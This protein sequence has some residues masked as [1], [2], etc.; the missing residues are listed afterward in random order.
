VRRGGGLTGRRAAALA[1][2]SLLLLLVLAQIVLPQIAASRIRSKLDRYGGG[3]ADV[4]VTAWPAVKL[5]WGD[6]DSV[7]VKAGRLALSPAQ[8]AGLL[9]E[10]RGLARLEISVATVKLGS[11]QLDHAVFEKRG[12]QLSA[13]AHASGAA[14]QAAL[15]AGTSVH[16]LRSG[17]G[18]V[19]VQAHGEL[20]GLGADV[21]ALAAPLDGRL[22]VR[23]TGPLL[24]G[25]RLTLFSN[26]HVHIDALAASAD[27]SGGYELSLGA[28]LR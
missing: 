25:L 15:P 2:G 17:G 10:G 27:G 4:S 19:E 22:V 6:A 23:P 28:L 8:A 21:T 11:L 1:A 12:E 7:H 5:L 3:G 14:V 24:G 9:W 18:Q 20:L 13:R 26:P 16:L